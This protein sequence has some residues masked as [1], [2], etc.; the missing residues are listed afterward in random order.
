LAWYKHPFA[1]QYVCWQY[2]FAT[3]EW[4]LLHFALGFLWFL[5]HTSWW[6]WRL[7]L[8]L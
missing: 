1:E 7:V 5:N 3:F 4:M 6:R 8:L 2:N